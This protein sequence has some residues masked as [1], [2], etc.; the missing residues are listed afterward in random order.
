MTLHF[1]QIFLTDARTFIAVLPFSAHHEQ[2]AVTQ[3][4]F[5][6]VHNSSAVEVVRTQLNGYAVTRQNADEIFAHSSRDVGQHF[7]VRFEL[8]LEHG[9]GQRLDDRCHDLNRVFF[10]QTVSTSGCFRTRAFWTE[11]LAYSVRTFDP[12]S[13]T[14][15]VCS[16]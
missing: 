10:R 13:V 4:L 16:K 9:V 8:H 11:W 7:V 3:D 1:T 12:V 2:H 15:T 5:V 14:A 6:A